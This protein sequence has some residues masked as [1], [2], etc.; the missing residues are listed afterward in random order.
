MR[1]PSF[2]PLFSKPTNHNEN[3]QNSNKLRKGGENWTHHEG[4][5]E[6]VRPLPPPYLGTL[7][8]AT[9]LP[10]D[11]FVVQFRKSCSHKIQ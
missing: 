7:S 6:E 5:R 8:F 9:E 11:R 2:Y 3:E 4:I 1:D 10:E